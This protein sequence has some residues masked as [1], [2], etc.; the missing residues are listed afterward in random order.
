MENQVITV[1]CPNCGATTKNLHNCDYC[2]SFLV[3][4]AAEGKDL[5]AYVQQASQFKN[6]GLEK[7]LK[8][9]LG[10]MKRY[11]YATFVDVLYA[12]GSGLQ[13]FPTDGNDGIYVK[14]DVDKTDK[15]LDRFYESALYDVM[16]KDDEFPTAKNEVWVANFGTDYEGAAK[17]VTQIAQQL[18]A[19]ITSYQLDIEDGTDSA[20]YD[21]EGN[22]LRGKG[23]G[24]NDFENLAATMEK[25][26]AE[27]EK[28]DKV[29]RYQLIGTA[30][31]GIAGGV[32]CIALFE[33]G[34]G[35]LAG[36]SA[37]IYG[38]WCGYKYFAGK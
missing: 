29:Y 10:I 7:V 22:Y 24:V 17:L 18:G 36:V 6:E 25:N 33:D 2:G 30:I 26:L 34:I 8:K 12:D 23:A 4:Q 19:T 27:R 16:V 28:G 31:A 32:A 21:T 15:V 9:Q 35:I 14:F 13:V 37:I 5:T 38:I 20:V 11:Q 3:Q 1:V